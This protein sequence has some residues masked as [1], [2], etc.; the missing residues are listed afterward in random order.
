VKKVL[1]GHSSYPDTYRKTIL[2][3]GVRVVSEVNDHI[4]SVSL[5]I[6]VRA[7][8]RYEPRHLNG[9]CHFIEHMLFKGTPTRDALSI[10][11]E[12]DSVG[13][14][15]NAFTSKEFTAFYAKVLK[16]DLELAV[17]LLADIFLNSIFPEE[18]II[19]EKQVI[20]Q[21]IHQLEDNPEELVHEI[22]GMNFWRAHALGQPILG[23]IPNIVAIDRDTLLSYKSENYLPSEIIVAAVGNLDHDRVI[24]LITERMGDLPSKKGGILTDEPIGGSCV[25]VEPK[26][27]EQ[28]HV[29]L[30]TNAPS[31]VAS[32]RYA[33]YILN[34]LLG[35]GMSSRLFQEIREKRGLAYNVYSFLSS[36]SD[37]GMLGIYAGCDPERLEELVHTIG[38]VTMG[39]A[40]TLTQ[41]EMDM[42]KNQIKGNLILN[43]ESS[44][45]QM[46]RL[47]KEEYYFGRHITLG[48]ILDSLHKVSLP[49][50]CHECEALLNNGEF[51][52]VALGPVE[53]DLNLQTLFLDN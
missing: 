33:A 20:C 5:G 31:A 17:D 28:V 36:L 25:Y 46:N 42:A 6:W 7:G 52:I 13:G 32:N 40:D 22:W 18:E 30:G 29:C 53:A 37:S 14:I 44:D 12:I 16:E 27:L 41:E 51:T 35:G 43:L 1:G 48:E 19:R 47:A 4:Q 38:R 2:P 24:D 23:T 3:N 34:T 50:L 15:L 10:A 8:S 11:K 9:I 21:E 26:D 45:A 39:I 49:E